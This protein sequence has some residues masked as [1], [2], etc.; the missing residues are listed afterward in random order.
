[1]KRV[2]FQGM[3]Q[4]CIPKSLLPFTGLSEANVCHL[5]NMAMAAWKCFQQ[6]QWCSSS[7][8]I[9]S[10]HARRDWCEE[11]ACTG[12][13]MLVHQQICVMQQSLIRLCSAA[14]FSCTDEQFVHMGS[15]MYSLLKSAHR[16]Y[17]A[18]RAGKRHR[19]CYHCYYYYYYHDYHYYHYAFCY[20]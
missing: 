16:T 12:W 1:M 19:Y 4:N 2:F 17:L 6:R 20:C 15:C 13:N 18:H 14:K 3:W 5:L 11:C 9:W 10:T 8:G 7:W